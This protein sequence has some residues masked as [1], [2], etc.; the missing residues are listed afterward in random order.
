M[1][2]TYNIKSEDKAAFLNRL[3]KAGVNVNTTKVIDDKLKGTFS[4]TFE[5]PEDIEKVKTILQQS[6]KINN[7]KEIIRS[8]VRE[9]MK[10]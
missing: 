4:I 9:Q 5:N 3:E 7:L 6:P 1:A 8:M 10:K 2:K